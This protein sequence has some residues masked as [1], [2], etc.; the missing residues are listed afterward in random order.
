MRLNAKA[1]GIAMGGGDSRDDLGFAA[2][3]ED[4]LFEADEALELLF[5]AILVKNGSQNSS[6]AEIQEKDRGVQ[7]GRPFAGNHDVAESF[8]DI[9]HPGTMQRQPPEFLACLERLFA[10]SFLFL[11]LLLFTTGFL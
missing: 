3:R 11:L 2:R 9:C 8:V 1:T 7:P 10:A 5:A 4:G 6:G